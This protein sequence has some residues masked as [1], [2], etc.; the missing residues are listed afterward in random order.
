MVKLSNV[1]VEIM[2]LIISYLDSE[3][4]FMLRSLSKWYAELVALYL[5]QNRGLHI[6]EV[7]SIFP[8]YIMPVSYITNKLIVSKISK[9]LSTTSLGKFSAYM[10]YLHHHG[11]EQCHEWD[12][13]S[14]EIKRNTKLQVKAVQATF[15][16]LT[17]KSN[18]NMTHK[19]HKM[20]QINANFKVLRHDKNFLQ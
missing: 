15:Q 4:L 2:L 12:K 11:H 17:Q 13:L 20:V 18:G 5:E 8:F 3:N 14:D 19:L 10:F 1:P 6:R 16:Y 9:K 7:Q